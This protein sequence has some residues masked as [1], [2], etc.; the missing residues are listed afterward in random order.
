[1]TLTAADAIATEGKSEWTSPTATFVLRRTGPADEELVVYLKAGGT[2]TSGKD[3]EAIPEKV[4][5]AAGERAK[6]LMVQPIDDSE[7]EQI[8]TVLLEVI[9]PES[10]IRPI[11]W[12]AYH[13]GRPHKAVAVILDNDQKR[14][15]CLQLPDGRFHVCLPGVDAQAYRIESSTNLSEWTDL[16]PVESSQ[17]AVHFVDPEKGSG[18]VMFYRIIPVLSPFSE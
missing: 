18:N 10:S 3:Y 16:G 9:L 6:R 11:G 12:P 14:P 17:G 2:A 7:V 1:M 8:E 15:P 5:L 4:V 13:L